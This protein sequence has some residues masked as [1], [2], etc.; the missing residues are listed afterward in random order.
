M[1]LLFDLL[2]IGLSFVLPDTMANRTAFAGVFLNPID[3]TRVVALLA[4]SGKEMF[5]PAGAQL[6]RSLGSVPQAVTFLSP[7]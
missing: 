3:A 5:G 6:V 7:C 1:V 4:I 2:I